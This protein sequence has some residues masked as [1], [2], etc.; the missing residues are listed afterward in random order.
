MK[1]ATLFL[2]SLL[3]FLLSSCHDDAAEPESPR[4]E[5]ESSRYYALWEKYLG[6]HF[7]SDTDEF[8]WGSWSPWPQ[9]HYYSLTPLSDDEFVEFYDLTDSCITIRNGYEQDYFV[10]LADYTDG[11]VKHVVKLPY[12]DFGI[13]RSVDVVLNFEEDSNIIP[14]LLKCYFNGEYVDDFGV[15]FTI[16]G[17]YK[18]SE[19]LVIEKEV[20]YKQAFPCLRQGKNVNDIMDWDPMPASFD[21]SAMKCISSP[22]YLSW[23]S[24]QWSGDIADIIP[25]PADFL[26]LIMNIPVFK[27]EDY[28]EARYDDPKNF[29]TRISFLE[30]M[31]HF[32]PGMTQQEFHEMDYKGNGTGRYVAGPINNG[33]YTSAFKDQ[34]IK[35]GEFVLIVKASSIFSQFKA[36]KNRLFFANLLRALLSEDR[37]YF[38]MKS[39]LIN[40]GYYDNTKEREF[41]MTLKDPQ[42]SRNVMEFVILP[43]LI[44]NKQAIKNYIRQDA[45][46]AANAETICSAVDHLEDIYAATTDLTLGYSLIE[47]QWSTI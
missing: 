30:L 21:K 35:T 45:E 8:C 2:M 20:K 26:Q 33:F 12:P 42:L 13:T 14:A 32:F 36:P 39:Q 22:L 44:E 19:G 29:N 1:K 37:C 5:A 46:L 23:N 9:D 4:G 17:D 18:K 25:N 10:D 16:S 6:K 24:S 40:T 41:H 38:E 43:I 34:K 27:T 47:D 3:A 31:A 11:M 7:T 15:T 28:L